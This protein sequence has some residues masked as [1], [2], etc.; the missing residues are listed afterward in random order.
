MTR[1]YLDASALV[2]IATVEAETGALRAELDAYADRFTSRITTI[3]VPRA[4]ARKDATVEVQ[5]LAGW[6]DRLSILELDAAIGETA[7]RLD[8]PTLRS[9]DAIHLASALAIADELDAFI[10]YDSRLAGAARAHGLKVI[11]PG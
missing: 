1:C 9:L 5:N 4:L 7:A 10:T 3:E 2:K 11:A 6:T 8:P